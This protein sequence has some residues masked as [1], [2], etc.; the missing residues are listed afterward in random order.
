MA[1]RLIF[2][3]FRYRDFKGVRDSEFRILC[4]S[5]VDADERF[6]HSRTKILSNINAFKHNHMYL[7]HVVG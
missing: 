6:N 3:Y 5:R 7:K 4:V 1:F 2:R